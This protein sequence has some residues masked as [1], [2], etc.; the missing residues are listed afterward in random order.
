MTCLASL[1]R[2]GATIGL[3]VAG[4][5]AVLLLGASPAYA[6]GSDEIDSFTIAYD[7]RPSGVLQ[8]SETVVWRFGTD[9]PRHGI[10]RDLV[11]RERYDAELDVVYSVSDIHVSTAAGVSHQVSTA[12][13]RS[14]DGRFEALELTIGDPDKTI[15][16]P[17]A[18]YVISY[19]VVGA[20]RSFPGGSSPYDELSWDV[21][22]SGNPAI[23]QVRVE[24]TLPGNARDVRCF[25][26]AI[27]AKLTCDEAVIGS[28]G[29]ASFSQ[30]DLA[31]GENV[32]IAV[33]LDPGVVADNRPH[34]EPSAAR[35]S[36]AQKTGLAALVTGG[37]AVLVGSPVIG[38]RWWRKN[39]RD[40]RYAGLTPGTSSSGGSTVT[41]V[42]NDPDVIIPVTFSPP[43]LSVAEAGLLV[44]RQLGARETAA[45]LVDL[46][47]R[48]ALTISSEGSDDFRIELSDAGHA[49]AP[50]EIVLIQELFAGKLPGSS[51]DL[52]QPGR[53]GAG[54][55]ALV[56]SIRARVDSQR[57]FDRSPFFSGP[58]SL[59]GVFIRV[60][61]AVSGL[62]VVAGIG[63]AIASGG[64]IYWFALPLVS[65]G[66]TFLVVSV[67]ARRGRLTARGRALCDQA[68]GFRTY[69]ATAEIDQLR[70]EEGVDIYSR[71]LPWAIVFEVT[72]RWTTVC[73]ELIRSGQLP[74]TSP[75]WYA[76]S[77]PLSSFDVG[78]ATELARGGSARRAPQD[79]R[80]HPSP[81]AAADPASVAGV[82]LAVVASPG[83][84]AVAEGAAVGS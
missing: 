69:L 34:L 15:S 9:S 24:A 70:F 65:L 14:K 58:R 64:W 81:P 3:S 10:K 71:Y 36:R 1:G 73:A 43:P 80:T 30:T 78:F 7:L 21:S 54:H 83:V 2:L 47:V 51:V 60:M 59:S 33:Q 17:T 4:V 42:P 84:V 52:M 82:L 62:G 31:A 45:T 37:V 46:A 13:K 5:F 49:R 19:S 12:T 55:L 28:D 61:C 48:G 35:L 25:R 11:V 6:A 67:K 79:P 27:T 75:A 20:M 26:G 53:L 41:V 66:L 39:G 29:K 8:V 56:T 63:L 22:G 68:E 23:K 50:H 16:A 72:D 40:R 57:W 74:D 38:Y 76:G 18:T 77:T 32:T 44:H